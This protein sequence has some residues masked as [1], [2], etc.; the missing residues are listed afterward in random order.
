MERTKLEPESGH[1][2]LP[3]CLAAVPTGC[4]DAVNLSLDITFQ[5]FQ[6]VFQRNPW[7]E[8]HLF[9]YCQKLGNSTSRNNAGPFVDPRADVPARKVR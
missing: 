6:E 7:K 2:T 8:V 1:H 5:H 3:E 4:P 9:A